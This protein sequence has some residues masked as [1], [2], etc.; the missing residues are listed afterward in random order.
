LYSH[1]YPQPTISTLGLHKKT[2]QRTHPVS[3]F[4]LNYSHNA[5]SL[6]RVALNIVTSLWFFIGGGS[7]VKGFASS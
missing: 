4:A 7:M 6:I 1:R 3:T 5:N 2:K